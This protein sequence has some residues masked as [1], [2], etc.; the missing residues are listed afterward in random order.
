MKENIDNF[1]KLVKPKNDRE[2]FIVLTYLAL[3]FFET[4]NYEGIEYLV[5]DYYGQM[6]SKG[7]GFSNPDSKFSP[8]VVDFGE[9]TGFMLEDIE[10]IKSGKITK[11]EVRKANLDYL[12]NYVFNTSKKIIK[13]ILVDLKQLATVACLEIRV[14]S[15]K[16]VRVFCF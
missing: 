1:L 15:L 5:K 2:L 4:D 11:D 16:E 7:R 9:L 13:S 12:K 10:K 6:V 8:S 3:I 14:Q